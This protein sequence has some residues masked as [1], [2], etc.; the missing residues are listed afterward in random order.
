MVLYHLK[1]IGSLWMTINTFG[2]HQCTVSKTLHEVSCAVS[3]HLSP[4][5][6]HLPSTKE[7]MQS[8]VVEFETKFG[9]VQA[10]GCVDGNHI[11]FRRPVTD[12]Q[13]YYK[14]FYS[15]NV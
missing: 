12:S 15:L 13:D 5:H 8:K 10:F 9:M 4:E 1:D 7:E 2:I 14:Q 6:L 3:K 11:P